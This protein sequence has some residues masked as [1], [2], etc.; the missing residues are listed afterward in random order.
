MSNENIKKL[1][2]QVSELE[3]EIFSKQDLLNIENDLFQ[4]KCLVQYS[5]FLKNFGGSI[6][7]ARRNN[8]SELTIGVN[9][10]ENA[11]LDE[12]SVF[13]NKKGYEFKQTPNKEILIYL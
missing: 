4:E 7:E 13:L 1:K 11:V 3:D 6:L 12:I 8:K 9:S 2:E 10:Y 5:N